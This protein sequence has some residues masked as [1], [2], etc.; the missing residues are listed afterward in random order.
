MPDGRRG[1]GGE[2]GGGRARDG[3]PRGRTG[4]KARPTILRRPLSQRGSQAWARAPRGQAPG[5]RRGRDRREARMG[6]RTRKRGLHTSIRPSPDRGGKGPSPRRAWSRSG[7]GPPSRLGGRGRRPGPPPLSTSH[8]SPTQRRDRRDV[9]AGG[10]TRRRADADSGRR[11]PTAPV[12]ASRDHPGFGAQNPA[13]NRVAPSSQRQ[14]Y[15][16][17]NLAFRR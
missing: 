12:C 9:R 2:Y 8:D 1:P 14:H 15:R 3:R 11:G 4:A 10:A 7:P 6:L 5:R 17:P 16:I 13:N